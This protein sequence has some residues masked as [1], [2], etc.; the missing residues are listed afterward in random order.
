V[1]VLEQRG[2]ITLP[3]RPDAF[4]SLKDSRWS[5]NRTHFFLEADRSSEIQ[6]QFGNKIRAYWH[7]LQQGLQLKKFGI[8]RFRVLTVTLTPER[9]N[10]LAKQAE[11]LVPQRAWKYFL[12]T[13]AK[14]FSLDNPAPIFENI[15]LQPGNA[16]GNLPRALVRPPSL[17]I[18]NPSLT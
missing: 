4:F 12:F 9:A 10:N 8:K 15:C 18:D 13:S 11:A 2:V 6:K 16:N 17:T 1:S 5:D 3:V 14:H 7:Y